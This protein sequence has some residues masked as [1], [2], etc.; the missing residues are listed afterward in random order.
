MPHFAAE[1]SVKH[2]CGF[3]WLP[4]C[5]SR[6]IAQL[7]VGPDVGQQREWPE[8]FASFSGSMRPLGGSVLRVLIPEEAR[9]GLTKD[10]RL[11][12]SFRPRGAERVRPSLSQLPWGSLHSEGRH[13]PADALQFACFIGKT[14]P[15]GPP[16]RWP[17][18]SNSES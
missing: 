1:A 13:L 16:S 9:R 5:N 11:G 2:F 12:L 14:A 18:P 3:V 10:L 8:Q 17:R 7:R 6:R 4:N 15:Q